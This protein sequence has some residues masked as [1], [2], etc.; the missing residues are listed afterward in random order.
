MQY[1]TKPSSI[2]LR[3]DFEEYAVNL[4]FLY[5]HRK[6]IYANPEYF[7]TRLPF[8][9]YGLKKSVCIGAILKAYDKG[10]PYLSVSEDSGTKEFMASYAG[11][12]LTGSTSGLKTVVAADGTV[13]IQLFRF[14][15]FLSLCK[16][17]ADCYHESGFLYKES[18]LTIHDIIVKLKEQK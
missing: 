13:E 1:K 11:S 2:Q 9:I 16:K 5:D 10:E 17:L 14:T 12:P 6:E 3:P 15:G 18:S 8:I 4:P 7:F